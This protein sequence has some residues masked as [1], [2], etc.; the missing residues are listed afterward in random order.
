MRNTSVRFARSRQRGAVLYTALILLI[1]LTIIGV[2]AARLQT[3]EAIMARNDHNHQLAM[4]AA[5][6]ALRDAEINLANGNWNVAQFAQ[7]G[8]GLYVLQ[9]EVQNPV[10]PGSIVDGFNWNQNYPAPNPRAMTYTGP[11]LGNAPASP[12]LTQVIIENLPP[13]ARAGDPLCTPSSQTQSCSV[14]RVTAHA[15]GGDASASAT[16]QSIIH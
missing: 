10:N 8:A 9:T 1:V 6:A 7:N 11:V 12:V 2:A 3:G 4:Q 5:E 14:Y 16:L 13:V 15:V